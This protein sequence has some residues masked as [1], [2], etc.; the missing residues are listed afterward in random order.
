MT[1]E[2]LDSFRQIEHHIPDSVRLYINNEADDYPAHWHNSYEVIM[3][4][5]NTYTALVDSASFEIRPGEVFIIPSGVVHE[6]FAPESGLRYLFLIDHEELVSI[7]GLAPL[8]YLFYPCVLLGPHADPDL[9]GQA[10]QYLNNAV[11]EFGRDDALSRAARRA[12]LA[13]FFTACGRMLSGS[14]RSASHTGQAPRTLA[15]MQEACAYIVDH[16]DEKLTLPGMSSWCGYSKYHFTRMFSTYTGIGFH[17]FL[18]R[19]R[20]LRCCRLLMDP[21]LSI[22]EV[23]LRSGFGS[24]ATFNRVFREHES[25]SPTEYREMR[26]ERSRIDEPGFGLPQLE[27]RAD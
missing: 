25:M 9:F 13:L 1:P 12:W 19:Q 10:Q 2:S 3:P 11:R 16:C 17:E 24:I 8:Q 18:T 7:D 22:T 26:R 6:L 20:M 21:N 27:P 15:V 14:R 5:E 4:V 23:A